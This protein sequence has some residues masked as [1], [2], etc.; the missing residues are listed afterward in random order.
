MKKP[1]E[2]TW[3]VTADGERIVGGSVEETE[4]AY[5]YMK[6]DGITHKM[7]FEASFDGNTDEDVQARVLLAATAPEPYR[8]LKE[9]IELWDQETGYTGTGRVADVRA[10]LK[11]AR[12]ET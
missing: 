2:E 4:R 5:V 10:L 12:G 11:K 7:A 9:L 8:A 6:Q 3:Y 1:W